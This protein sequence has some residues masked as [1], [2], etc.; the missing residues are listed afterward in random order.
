MS[1][2]IDSFVNTSTEGVDGKWWISKPIMTRG[3]IVD[4]RNRLRWAVEV[5]RG[6]AIAVHFKEDEND[7]AS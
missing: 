5:L 3:D 2:L 4:I 6:K 1:L 7:K